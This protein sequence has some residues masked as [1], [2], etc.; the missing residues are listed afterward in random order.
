MY[1]ISCIEI[2]LVSNIIINNISRLFWGFIF[3]NVLKY[4]IN[5]SVYIEVYIYF[6][7]F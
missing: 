5:N 3:C 4:I 6:N 1:D 7:K 2:Y